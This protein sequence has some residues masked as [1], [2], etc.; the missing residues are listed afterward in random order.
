MET[1]EADLKRV[2]RVSE[3]VAEITLKDP[4]NSEYYHV[5]SDKLA[6]Y[7]LRKY[8]QDSNSIQTKEDIELVVCDFF[9]CE[10]NVLIDLLSR[11]LLV[12]LN[13]YNNNSIER[14]N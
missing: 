7:I 12:H 5:Q 4:D 11:R 1:K 8:Y 6:E 2:I 10:N 14:R 9:N 13:E 3:Y